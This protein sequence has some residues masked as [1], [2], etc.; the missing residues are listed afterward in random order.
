MTNL[1]TGQSPG[2][3]TEQNEIVWAECVGR[4]APPDSEAKERWA[5]DKFSMLKTSI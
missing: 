5:N 3:M 2:K 1:C 4:L